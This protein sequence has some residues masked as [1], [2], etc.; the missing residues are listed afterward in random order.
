MSTM[1]KAIRQSRTSAATRFRIPCFCLIVMATWLGWNSAAPAAPY[2]FMSVSGTNVPRNGVAVSTFTS[3]LGNGFITVDHNSTTPNSLG[4]WGAQDNK[5]SFIIP[6]KFATLFPGSGN[7]QGHLA[8]SMYGDPNPPPGAPAPIPNVTT[9][10]FHLNNYFGY[11]PD[12]AFGIWNTTTEVGMPVYNIQLMDA[13][14]AIVSPLHGQ[15]PRQ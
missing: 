12:L 11:L 2:T 7:V 14:N 4:N 5:N 9:V 6:S 8:Q 1:P 3:G 15:Y 13:S 10:T